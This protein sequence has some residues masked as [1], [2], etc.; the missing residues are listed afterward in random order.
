MWLY[1]RQL[2]SG[3]FVQARFSN[4]L[5]NKP[6]CAIWRAA[7]GSI[8]FHEGEPPP[9]AASKHIPLYL[10]RLAVDLYAADQFK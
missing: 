1:E 2:S 3:A 9:F 4:F 5:Q 6:K 7:Q 8:S 10:V